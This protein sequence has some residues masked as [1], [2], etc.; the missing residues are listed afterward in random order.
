VQIVAIALKHAMLLD[1]NL[2]IQITGRAAIH[3]GLTISGRA[4]PHTVINTGRDF[5]F[6][7]L[8]ALDTA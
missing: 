7:C 8:V 5:D 3:A 1:V 4:N 6:Q 2:D